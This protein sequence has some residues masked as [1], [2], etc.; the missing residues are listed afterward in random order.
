MPDNQGLINVARMDAQNSA[1]Q[2][3]WEPEKAAASIKQDQA[4]SDRLSSPNHRL[5]V[6]KTHPSAAG[7]T[8]VAALST[9][10]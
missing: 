5:P 1:A 10:R 2:S 9:D 3:E 8:R 4:T 7:I 6:T